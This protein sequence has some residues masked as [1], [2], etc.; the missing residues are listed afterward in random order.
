[1]KTNARVILGVVGRRIVL[2][3]AVLLTLVSNTWADTYDLLNQPAAQIDLISGGTD[4]VSGQ[5][6]VADL[7][8]YPD[9][10]PFNVTFSITTPSGT[11]YMSSNTYSWNIFS[12]AGPQATASY[13]ELP[14]GSEFTI[15]AY[16]ASERAVGLLWEWGVTP[17]YEGFVE[18]DGS[19]IALFATVNNS[20]PWSPT[21]DPTNGDLIIAT[22]VPEPG[23]L[24][25]LVSALLGLAAVCLRRRTARA[26]RLPTNIGNHL[27]S[28]KRSLT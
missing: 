12:T 15:L 26:R 3:A 22:A 24:T 18:Y 9:G 5:I 6:V 25:L 16:T 17:D 27:V 13:L 21:I 28:V 14:F 23:T 11:V 19:A 4:T 7:G 10:G 8:P 1:M 20:R 2:W